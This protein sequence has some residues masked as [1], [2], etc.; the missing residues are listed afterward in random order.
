[1][2]RSSGTI[3]PFVDGVNRTADLVGGSV[4]DSNSM[5]T[6]NPVKIGYNQRDDVYITGCLSDL[7]VYKGVA[8]YTGNF[9]PAATNPDIVPDTPSGVAYDSVTETN[10]GSVSFDGDGDYL[11]VP[12]HADLRLG[13]DDFCVEAFVYYSETSGNGTIAGLWNSG[14][15]RISWLFQI[16]SDNRRL[17]G[18][19]STYGS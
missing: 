7:R 2:V 5:T 17:R 3:I 9:I 19:Y 8:K 16:E 18:F 1:M 14:A 15:N 12:N 11:Q 4:S 6:T 13:S 10:N